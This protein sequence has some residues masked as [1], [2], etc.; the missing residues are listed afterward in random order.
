MGHAL[1]PDGRYLATGSRVTDD[2]DAGGV[3]QIWEVATG[4]CVNTVP[5]IDGGIGWPDYDGTIQ[6]SADST[7]LAMAYRTNSVGVWSPT[8]EQGEPIASISVS[9][10]N[11]RPSTFALSLDGLSVYFHCGTN[12]DGG[13][14][15]CLVPLDRGELSWLPNYV[16]TDHPYT[17]A[18]QIPEAVRGEFEPAESED[19]FS[20]GQ[21]IDGP[22]WSPDGTRLHGTNALAV[23]AETRRVLWYAPAEFAR[24]SPSGDRVATVT[25]RGLFLRDAASAH[26]T[27]T[28]NAPSSC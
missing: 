6:W 24:F 15:G 27:P 18:R 3:L 8:A 11:S 23:D 14:Q 25:H 12:G 20:V 9:D 10:G 4:R 2:Y 17:T 1:S 28:G 19:G 5:W 13:L 21:W 7:R 16:K 22:A 26:P